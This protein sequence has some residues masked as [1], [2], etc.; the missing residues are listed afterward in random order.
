VRKTA[1]SLGA[2]AAL[3][4]PTAAQA[5][6]ALDGAGMAWPWALPF[7]GILLSIALGPLL[8]P[9]IWH[10]HYGKISAAWALATL[11]ALAVF[12]V[13]LGLGELGEWLGMRLG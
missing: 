7:A 4:I 9:K 10:H 11:A 13:S 12:A 1:P 5:A 8:F 2:L 3:L 6:P